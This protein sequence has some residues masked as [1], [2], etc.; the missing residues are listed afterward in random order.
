MKLLTLLCLTTVPVVFGQGP[1][2]LSWGMQREQVI[3]LVGNKAVDAKSAGDILYLTTVPKPNPAFESYVLLISPDRGLLKINAIGIDLRTNGFG[4][5]VHSAFTEIADA[6]SGTY[7]TPKIYEFLRTGSIWNERQDWMMGLL[8]KERTLEAFWTPPEKD[9][10]QHITSVSLSAEALS[11]EKAYLRLS[12]E[13]E[14]FVQYEDS[15]KEK[16]KSVF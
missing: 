1:F 7:G 11:Q 4:S 15:K 2:G 13:F 14:G 16:A 9:T 8:K 10:R 3:Q 6:V 12:Y 5:E